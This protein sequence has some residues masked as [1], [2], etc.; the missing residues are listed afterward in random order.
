MEVRMDTYQNGISQLESMLG[1]AQARQIV[2]K[3]HSLSPA[4][5]EEALSVVFG[6]TWARQGI[7]RRVRSLCSIGILAALGRT[8]ALGINYQLALVNG[9]SEEE[10]VEALLQVAIYA[11]YPAALDALAQWHQ[12]KGTAAQKESKEM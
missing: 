4:F 2:A 3:F 12:F 5:A 1:E 9:V 10:I 11:G 6:R 7:D 8:N